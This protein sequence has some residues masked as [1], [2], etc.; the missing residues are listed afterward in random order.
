MPAL[1]ARNA[2]CWIA[3]GSASAHGSISPK[4]DVDRELLKCMI[5]AQQVLISSV[6]V[7]YNNK[8]LFYDKIT[9]TGGKLLEDDDVSD[10]KH[11]DVRCRHKHN[12]LQSPL[13]RG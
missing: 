4:G 12:S 7:D 13:W 9:Q 11:I 1:M 5:F 3:T 10:G 6:C 8:D 2:T